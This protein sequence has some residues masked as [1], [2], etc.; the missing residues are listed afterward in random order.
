MQKFYA[1][2]KQE[3]KQLKEAELELEKVE[4]ELKRRKLTQ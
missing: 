1:D 2:R 4:K 3:K